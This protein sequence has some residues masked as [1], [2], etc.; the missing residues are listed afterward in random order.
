MITQLP[1]PFGKPPGQADAPPPRDLVTI[2]KRQWLV[3]Y[4][5]HRRA[6]HYI[7]RVQDDGSVK[8]T[9]PRGGSRRGAEAFVR[10]KVGWIERE[11][12][13]MEMARAS[14]LPWH[15]GT[16]VL[17]RGEEH[18]LRVDKPHGVVRLASETIPLSHGAEGDLRRPVLAHLRAMAV[19]ELTDRVMELAAQVGHTVARVTVRNQRSRWGSCSPGGR[20]SLNWR[21][22]QAPNSVRDY[23]LL[24]ELTHIDVPNHSKRFWKKLEAV[25]PWYREANAWLKGVTEFGA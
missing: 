11:R 3:A 21:L 20:I 2:G 16:S 12:Y 23:I 18:P 13:R 25:C 5:R 15:D 19:K 7:L 1:L 9:I 24:H 6:R 4:V 17:L 10:E 22:I 8:V 14:R